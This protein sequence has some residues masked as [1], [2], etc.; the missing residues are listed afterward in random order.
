M[1]AR[2]A[3]P[4]EAPQVVE[5]LSTTE[6]NLFDPSLLGYPSTVTLCVENGRPLLYMPLQV[7]LTMESLGKMPGIRK[8]DMAFALVEMIEAVKRFAKGSGITEVYFLCVE[9]TVIGQ[10]EKF[11]FKRVMEDKEKGMV[12]FTMKVANG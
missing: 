8:R 2:L 4:E 5:W 11:G 10:A 7:T 1:N 9:E 3:R 6:K 12:L